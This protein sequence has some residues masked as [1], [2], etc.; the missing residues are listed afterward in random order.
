[1]LLLLFLLQHVVL[2]LVQWHW[3][4]WLSRRRASPRRTMLPLELELHQALQLQ[5][6]PWEV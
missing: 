6:P 1:M 5:Q 3:R 4:Q 2:L